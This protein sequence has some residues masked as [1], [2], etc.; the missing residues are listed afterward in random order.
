[1][2]LK[3][4]LQQDMLTAMKAGEKEKV[5]VLRMAKAA[6]MK[7]EV[8]GG[9]KKD[10]SDEEVL[11]IIGKEV[12]QRKEAAQVYIQGG[13]KDLADKEE[14]EAAILAT[15]L[16][17][18]MSE[19]EIRVVVAEV[20]AATGATSQKEIGKVM[21]GLMPKVKGKADGQLV[22]KIVRELLPA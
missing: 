6:I 7:F 9:A 5:D 1:M 11:T 20:I 14:S 17:A 16:P 4:Q 3:E 21:G 15:Y 18:Q 12:K 2:K 19:E 22:N 13:R 8:S 10:I